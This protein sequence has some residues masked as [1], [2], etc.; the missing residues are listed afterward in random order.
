MRE[1]VGYLSNSKNLL[2]FNV[3]GQKW[4]SRNWILFRYFAITSYDLAAISC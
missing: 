4:S 1:H 2:N 3:I